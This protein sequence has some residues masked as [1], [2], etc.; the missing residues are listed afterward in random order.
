[1][2][3]DW[4]IARLYNASNLTRM[5]TRLDIGYHKNVGATYMV[6]MG[7]HEAVWKMSNL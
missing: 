2:L 1:M 6:P 3:Q 4:V 7:K 5:L